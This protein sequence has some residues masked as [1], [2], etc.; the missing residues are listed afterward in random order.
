MDPERT[1]QDTPTDI[2]CP[3][4]VDAGRVQGNGPWGA[5]ILVFSLNSLFGEGRGR[6]AE[7][8]G[9]VCIG[10]R[11]LLGDTPEVRTNVLRA[12]TLTVF[13]ELCP[14]VRCVWAVPG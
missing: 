8:P 9:V 6:T 7:K 4:V 12:G 13:L 14:T 11:S 10:C 1:C 5:Q 2:P 3:V